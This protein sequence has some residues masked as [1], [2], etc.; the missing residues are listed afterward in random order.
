MLRRHS[1]HRSALKLHHGI[2]EQPPGRLQRSVFK[3]GR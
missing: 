1:A 2:A 3:C